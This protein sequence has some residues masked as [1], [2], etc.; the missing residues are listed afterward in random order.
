MKSIWSE[1][2]NIKENESL[3]GDIDTDIVIIGGGIAGLLI[4]YMLKMK[5]KDPIVIDKGKVLKGNTENTTAKITIQHDLIY[6]KL[7]KEFGYENAEKY[8]KANKLAIDT[9][10]KIISENNIECNFE[11]ADSYIYSLNNTKKLESEYEAAIKLGIDAEL[12]D[13]IELPFDIAK[14]LKFKDQAN[15]NPIQFLNYIANDLKIYENTK[16]IGIEDKVVITENGKIKANNIVVATHFPIINTPGYYFL[17]MHQERGYVI[18]LENAQIIKGMYLDEAENGYSF[19][20][21]KDLLILGASAKRT[22]SNEKGG[23]YA[24]LR[25]FAYKLYPSAI[26]KYKWSAQDC[27]PQ[28]GIPYIGHYSKDLENIYVATGFN[29]WG[30]TTSMVSAI[31]ISNMITGVDEEFHSIFSPERFDFTASIKDMM[32]DGKETVYNFIS[33]IVHIPLETI[34]EIKNGEGKIVTYN[35]EKIGVYKDNSGK[36]YKVNTRCPHL[37]CEL[38]WNADDLSWD[39]PCHGSRFDYEGKLMDSPSIKNLNYDK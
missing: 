34:E 16:A 23:E 18:A 26:E 19:R 12:V 4:A 32:K 29:K 6:D 1:S 15:F 38:N 25:E 36:V 22:G 5:G 17:R 13:E 30:M 28:D 3:N 27:V 39:C 8:A 10:K 2:Y 20:R 35:G 14:A 37:G 7:I 24:R 21:Y 11:I 9:Y 31:I 33:E